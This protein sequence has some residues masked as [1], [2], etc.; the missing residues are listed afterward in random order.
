MDSQKQKSRFKWV[1][2]FSF[3]RLGTLTLIWNPGRNNPKLLLPACV[4]FFIGIWIEKGMG[5]IVPGRVPIPMGEVVDYAPGWV[6]VS[7]RRGI[8]VLG[9]F[10]AT[11][12]LKPALKIEQRY[13]SSSGAEIG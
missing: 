2:G 1:S 11:M 4:P 6:E 10:V 12:L 8:L 9:I 5:L 7:V 13:E 3:F